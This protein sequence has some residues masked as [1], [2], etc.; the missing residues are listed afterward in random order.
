MRLSESKV[1]KISIEIVQ[2]LKNLTN[3]KIKDETRV[4]KIIREEINRFLERDRIL[5]AEA[6]EKIKRHKREI[7]E[8]STEWNL[9][10]K[11]YYKESQMKRGW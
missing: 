8:G 5:D 6:R 3:V 7:L 1:N 9:L 2:G 10:Y 11:R 4:L